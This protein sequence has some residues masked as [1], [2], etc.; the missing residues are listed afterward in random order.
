MI[1]IG[2]AG[3]SD[4]FY[5]QGHKRTLEAPAWLSEMGLT[6]MEYSCGH[7]VSISEGTARAIGNEARDQGIR[8]S[9]HAPYYINCATQDAQ[10]REKTI[11]Y[12]V[13]SARAIDWMGGDR[14]VFHIGSPGKQKR[15]Q[16][17]SSCHATIVEARRQMVDQ[18][19]SH[20]HLCPE[21]MGR[22]SQIGT[23]DEVLSVCGLDDSFIPALDFGH[24]HTIDLG[25]LNSTDDFRR[26]L[27]QMIDALGM[28]RVRHF[29]AHFSRIEFTPKGEKMH[30][31]FCDT[32]YGPDFAHLAPL[33]VEYG[34]QPIIICESKGTQA[35]DARMIRQ[36]LI[37]SGASI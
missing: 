12:L 21:T 5:E 16:A 15:D 26:I 2:P 33:I 18:G 11:G 28:D 6:A 32:Q 34:L 29:H 22:I 7:G 36:L 20:I 3:N 23:L 13:S 37:E 17:I 19:L 35:D 4:R 10:K 27:D 31:R 1:W 25:A 30:R 14:V 9:I 8:M 24:L